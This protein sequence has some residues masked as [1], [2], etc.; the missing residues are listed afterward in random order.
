M[1]RVTKGRRVTKSKQQAEER[2]G[3]G[4]IIEHGDIFF[5]YRPKIGA[6][7]VKDIEN[8]QRFYMVMFPDK[9]RIHRVFLLG[10]KQLPEM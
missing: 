4:K 5:F 2:A 6:E 8:V 9:S 3:R 10:Q 1:K 7:E